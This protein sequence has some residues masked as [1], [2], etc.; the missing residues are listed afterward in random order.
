M[1][2][3]PD[4]LKVVMRWE[5]AHIELYAVRLIIT[6]QSTFTPEESFTTESRT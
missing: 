5:P 4:S 3:R 6:Y 1:R 2:H